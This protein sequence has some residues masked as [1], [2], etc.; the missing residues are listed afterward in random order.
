MYK[1]G[2]VPHNQ[3]MWVKTM[4]KNESENTMPILE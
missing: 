2:S 4:L 3:N 1:Q